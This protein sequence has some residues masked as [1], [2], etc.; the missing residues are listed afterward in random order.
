[1]ALSARA[2]RARILRRDSTDAERRLWSALRARGLDGA[3]FRRQ[4][5]IDRYFADFACVNLRLVIELD[6]GQH[7]DP[8]H[9]A[10]DAARTAVL[11]TCG[12]RVL[13]FSNLDV[14]Q[15]LDGVCQSISSQITAMGRG[16]PDTL[17]SHR[18]RGQNPPGNS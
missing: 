4:H 3:R 11:E 1:M 8:D 12:W 7:T 6:G 2:V 10:Y 18:G 14:L 16:P 15:N 13:R 5:P 9:A 17:L